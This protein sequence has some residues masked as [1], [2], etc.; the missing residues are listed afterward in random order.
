[1][2]W[3]FYE[4]KGKQ[5]VRWGDWKGVR[6]K[7]KENREGPIELY[8]LADDIGETKNVAEK[9]PEIVKKIANIIR[10]ARTDSEIFKF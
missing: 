4:Q 2:Y 9:H 1:M 8:N 6:L 7:V 5:A 3:E 10:Q